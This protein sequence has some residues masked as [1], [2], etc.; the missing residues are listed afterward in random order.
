MGKTR[1]STGP[2]LHFQVKDAN[3]NDVNINFA[4]D[5]FLK[6]YK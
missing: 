5:E 1:N 6:N 4:I 3:S 2:H